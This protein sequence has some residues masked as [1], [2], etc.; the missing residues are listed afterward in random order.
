MSFRTRGLDFD[1]FRPLVGLSDDALRARG[2]R[3]VIADCSPGYPDRVELRDAEAGESV[4]LLNHVHQPAD[5]PFRASHA[6]YVLEH[7]GE[8]FDRVDEVPAV[9][10]SRMLSLRGFDDEGMLVAGELCA[11]AQVEAS[12]ERLLG[13]A[14]VAYLHLHYATFGCYACR[15]DRA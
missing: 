2:A 8:T 10:R 12:I 5:S 3:R 1:A 9:L 7:A 14:R 15:V 4:L 13:N 11:G 6:I